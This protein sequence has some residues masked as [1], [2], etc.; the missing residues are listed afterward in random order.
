MANQPAVS[1]ATQDTTH[2]KIYILCHSQPCPISDDG[3][4]PTVYN[5]LMV[6]LQDKIDPNNQYIDITHVVPSRF[7]MAQLPNSPTATPNRSTSG[8][9][10]SDYFSIN[11]F[12]KAVVLRDHET[13]MR[14]SVPSSPH[15]LV[16]PN[17]IHI[18]ILER[19]I[20]PPSVHEY[21]DLFSTDAPSVLVD[22][23]FELS[24]QDGTLLFIYPT[25]AGATTFASTYL[26]PLLDPLLRSM[27]G[28]HALSADIGVS[29]GK[30]SAVEH[31]LPYDGTLRKI[32]LLLRQL[33]RGVST[34]PAGPRP[35]PK[36]TLLQAG[37]KTVPL[38]RATW[39]EWW[40]AQEQ[41][42]VRTAMDRYF[43]RGNRLPLSK[44]VTAGALG[45]EI[46]D[47]LG[48]RTYAEYD[49]PREGVEVGV[50]VIKRTG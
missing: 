22:R 47:G 10:P 23:L 18:S 27:V 28:I 19:Y 33:S 32:N 39:L 15:P 29:V 8:A 41:G 46:L 2:L 9:T 25:L 16:V 4:K 21:N 38:D 45:R 11:I 31:I 30:M 3:S 42:R 49:S 20:P 5:D 12:P 14:S 17:S 13:A 6:Q 36:F 35:A 40:I 43:A 26:G 50:F 24:P 7:S 44:D 37:R 1:N 48:S 34:A